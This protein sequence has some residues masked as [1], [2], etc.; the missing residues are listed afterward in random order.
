MA[1][2]V[3]FALVLLLTGGAAAQEVSK[4]SILTASSPAAGNR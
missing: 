2:A 3:F 4:T 1:L